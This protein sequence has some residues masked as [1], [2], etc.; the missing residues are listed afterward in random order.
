MTE[1]VRYLPRREKTEFLGGKMKSFHPFGALCVMAVLVSAA[2]VSA[3]PPDSLWSQTYGGNGADECYSVQQTSDGGY[4]LAGYTQSFG[5]GSADFWLVKTDTHGDSL[6]SRTFGGGSY[7][8]CRSVQ[9]TSDGGYIMAGG[10]RSFGAGDCDFWLVK[11]NANGDSLWSR[12]FGGAADDACYSAQQTSDSGYVLAGITRS[13]G[14]GRADFWLVKTDANGDILWTA[15]LG[16]ID[17]EECHAV[18]QTSD[19]GYILAG[20]VYLSGTDRFSY[21]LMKMDANGDSLWSRTY[22]GSGDEWC[23]SVQQTSD[24]GYITAG[25][26]ESFGAGDYD[27]WLVKTDVDGDSLWSRTFGGS[28]DDECS[29]VQQTSDGGYILGGATGSFGADSW[30]LWLV[31]TDDDGDSL[32][33]RS[34]GGSYPD[35]CS[36]VQ[37]TSD[38]GYILVGS[39]LSFGAGEG[40][41]WLVKTDAN[42]DSLWSRTFGGNDYDGCYS[43]QET[44]DGGYILAGETRSFGAGSYDFWLVKT[45]P[46]DAADP[47]SV[48]MPAQY[49]LRPNYPNP[50]NPA[51]QIAYDISKTSNVTLTVFDLLGREVATLVDGVQAAGTHSVTFDGTHLPSGIYFYR[52]QAGDF[53]AARKMVL[54]K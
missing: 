14:M 8:L 41:F 5:A 22:G 1:S 20:H 25:Y 42:G 21:L 45:G 24:G 53:V 40:D 23:L 46:E 29:S 48:S 19:G 6:W 32:W 10:T 15:A 13:F 31:K 33:S 7:D 34:F 49:G 17:W 28:N 43:V 18:Q 9:Q 35:W 2:V 3:Q 39:T 30:D 52:L 26:T 16:G 12:A 36:S 50:F 4:V 47:I 51:T 27:F 11:T 54:L 37:Q 44:S 38:G